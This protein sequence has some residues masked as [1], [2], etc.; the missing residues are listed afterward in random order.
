MSSCGHLAPFPLTWRRQVVV[1]AGGG[2]GEAVAALVWGEAGEGVP[3]GVPEVRHGA[4]GCGAQLCFQ[5]GENLFDWVELGAVG[6]RVEQPR[7]G[8]LDLLADVADLVSLQVVEDR[9][10]AGPQDWDEVVGDVVAKALA[11]CGAIREVESTR[12]S[13]AQSGGDGRRF[14]MALRYE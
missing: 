6:R 7:A 3:D 9:S 12:A 14:V 11:V 4:G 5:L 10:V 8:R 13:G 2:G 1:V